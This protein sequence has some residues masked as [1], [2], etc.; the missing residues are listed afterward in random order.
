M[1]EQ[2]LLKFWWLRCSCGCWHNL[3]NSVTTGPSVHVDFDAQVISLLQIK[4]WGVFKILFVQ[5]QLEVP[6]YYREISFSYNP[7]PWPYYQVYRKFS[8]PWKPVT[9]RDSFIFPGKRKGRGK[10]EKENREKKES[11]RKRNWTFSRFK[12]KPNLGSGLV[13]KGIARSCFSWD[14]ILVQSQTQTQTEF[15]SGKPE[16]EVVLFELTQ[17]TSL[18]VCQKGWPFSVWCKMSWICPFSTIALLVFL[19][20]I[21]LK[22]Q[23]RQVRKNFLLDTC[24]YLTL[25]LNPS[26]LK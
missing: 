4:W 17:S 16:E 8:G 12:S 21:S 13:Q 10:R 26:G 7:K 11:K 9:E 19:L 15:V 1:T 23:L 24:Y 22:N 5:M 25:R 6:K 3:N 18:A 2:Q 14:S 20:L